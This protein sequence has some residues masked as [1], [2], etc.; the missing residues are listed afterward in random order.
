VGDSKSGGETL[1]P[2][3]FEKVGSCNG[4]NSI[5]RLLFLTLITKTGRG[6]CLSR[7]DPAALT[8]ISGNNKVTTVEPIQCN[9]DT[10]L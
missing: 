1:E 10:L 5:R 2:D 8:E 6:I 3:G 9:E 4:S 7:V